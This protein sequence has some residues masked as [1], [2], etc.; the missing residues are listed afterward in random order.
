MFPRRLE[1]N[2]FYRYSS[3]L[4]SLYSPRCR[5]RSKWCLGGKEPL[6]C[7]VMEKGWPLRTIKRFWSISLVRCA[8]LFSRLL[9]ST[10]LIKP[11]TNSRKFRHRSCTD[12]RLLEVSVIAKS[13][14]HDHSQ[15]VRRLCCSA[16]DFSNCWFFFPL[17]HIINKVLTLHNLQ[18]YTYLF[19]VHS[20]LPS[21]PSFAQKLWKPSVGTQ[22]ESCSTQ[23]L[24]HPSAHFSHIKIQTNFIIAVIAAVSSRRSLAF[25]VGHCK[26]LLQ[27]SSRC[28]RFV[29]DVHQAHVFIL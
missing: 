24:I 12:I 19:S 7:T 22:D 5:T 8:E 23:M 29:L 20:C 21:C 11:K 15:D 28:L 18:N 4:V 25:V 6:H 10:S 17:N 9:R 27:M 1:F 14:V 13:Q 16:Y 26:Y 2:L 3:F